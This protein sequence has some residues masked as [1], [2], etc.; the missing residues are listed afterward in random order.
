[1]FDQ[2]NQFMEKTNSFTLFAYLLF[3]FLILFGAFVLVP[4]LLKKFDL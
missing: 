1:M 2:I 4:W 3:L